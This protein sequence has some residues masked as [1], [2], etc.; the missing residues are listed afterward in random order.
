[1]RISLNNIKEIDNYLFGRFSNG[2]A[3]VFEARLLLE[4]SLREELLFQQ[5]AHQA[6]TH[7]SRKELKSEIAAVGH[8]LANAPENR[9]YIQRLKSLFTN[10]NFNL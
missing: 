1:M 7:F 4:E 3:I 2:D 5:V 9:N 6:I 10:Q 8:K